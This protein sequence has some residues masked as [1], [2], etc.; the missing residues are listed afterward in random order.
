MAGRADRAVTFSLQPERSEYALKQL[1]AET[2]ENLPEHEICA[3]FDPDQTA[4][5]ITPERFAKRAMK[6][7]V[8]VLVGEVN[9]KRS[10]WMFIEFDEETINKGTLHVCRYPKT[11]R[12]K[13]AIHFWDLFRSMYPQLEVYAP[14]ITRQARMALGAC[15]RRI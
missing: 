14:R 15:Q 6:E 7:N 2:L 10:G 9:G 11:W 1:Y 3:L 4:G 12:G 5:T 13:H 8:V